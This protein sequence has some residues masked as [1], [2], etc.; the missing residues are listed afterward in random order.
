[1]HGVVLSIVLFGVEFVSGEERS[2]LAVD[3]IFELLLH[4][5]KVLFDDFIDDLFELIFES[6]ESSGHAIEG[7]LGS[8]LGHVPLSL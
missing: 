7:E 6:W 5:F 2:L 1:M 4:G 3:D 8:P